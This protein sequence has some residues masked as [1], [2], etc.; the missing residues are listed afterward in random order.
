MIT[1]ASHGI[2]ANDSVRIQAAAL[3]IEAGKDAVHVENTGDTTRGFFYMQSGSLAANAQGDGID[4]SAYLQIEG[5]AISLCTGGGYQNGEQHTSFMGG[6]GGP[7]GRP[8]GMGWNPS[9]SSTSASTDGT[10][11][12]GMKAS[13]SVLINGGTI[14]IDSADD[15]IHSNQSAVIADGTLSIKTGDDGIHADEYLTVSGGVVR[16]EQSYEGLEAL[17]I[18]ICGGDIALICSDDGINAAGGKD[19]SGFGFGGDKFGGRGG[20]GGAAGTGSI[21]ISGGSLYI[22]ASGDG[23]DANGTLKIS[24]GLT[25]VCGPT[26]GD[27]AVLD[28]DRSG[29]IMGGTFIGTGAQMMAQTFSASEQG[30]IALRTG[31]QAAN[32]PIT[33]TDASGAL[34]LSYEPAM[35]YQIVIISTPTLEKGASYTVTVGDQS[36]T[37]EAK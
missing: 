26:Q 24:G 27:T 19:E 10:S 13:Q 29:E 5:G 15:A 12:K 1:A 11:T 28:Y 20:N 34:I 35:P 14:E 30:V 3:T 21:L 6:P 7:G 33:L 31:N 32:T 18:E 23:I 17:H 36:D 22:N 37:F 8:G 9:S 4:A 25:T 2:D 16:V